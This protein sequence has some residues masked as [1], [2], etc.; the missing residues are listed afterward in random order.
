MKYNYYNILF[1]AV[2][3]LFHYVLINPLEKCIVYG[4]SDTE[5]IR[6]PERNCRNSSSLECLGMPSGHSE[7]VVIVCLL[8]YKL[9]LLSLPLSLVIIVLIGLQRV[10]ASRHTIQQVLAGWSVGL[11]YSTLYLYIWSQYSIVYSVTMSLGITI[12]LIISFT[13]IIDTK[14][15]EPVPNWVSPELLPIVKKK[16]N[17]PY[18]VKILCTLAPIFFHRM[19]PF[20]SWSRLEDVLDNLLEKIGRDFD[21][22]VGVKSGGAIIASY[23]H[24]KVPDVPMYFLKLK[25]LNTKENTSAVRMLQE[26]VH[27][28]ILYTKDVFE[29]SEGITADISNRRV[30][31]L[32]ET[33]ASGQ[34]ILFAKEYLEKE[35][36]VASVTLATVNIH[37]VNVK[38]YI[39]DDD[40][41]YYS[42]TEKVAIFPWGYDN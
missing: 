7:C 41:I 33:I 27:K 16:Q 37:N 29:V 24:T 39:K 25:R 15:H 36:H 17:V 23:I 34:T 3:F 40:I 22:I 31:L 5:A 9:N 8:L 35:K 1:I 38:S 26:I 12:V 10:Y 18:S 13:R 11:L 21:V 42:K 14:V 20:Y 6:R 30:L 28:N 2:I 4:I 19:A 32:D